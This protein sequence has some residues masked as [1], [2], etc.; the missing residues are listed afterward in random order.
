[1]KILHISCSPRG[2]ASGSYRLSE[3]IVAELLTRHPQAAVIAR[4]LWQ[5]PEVHID[6]AYAVALAAGQAAP[7]GLLSAALATS[8]AWIGELETADCLVI[9]TP[10]HNFT[11]PA[12]LKTWI[13]HVVRIGRTFMPT[14]QGKAGLLADRP[15]YVAVSAG[16]YRTGERARSPDFLEPYLRAILATIGLKNLHFFSLEAQSLGRE[17]ADEYAASAERE[18]AAHFASATP[19]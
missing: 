4:P 12:A 2:H 10:L 18:V 1:M 13:D 9:A 5:A 15:V 3:R 17:R 14:A 11:V 6:A 19:D 8:E 16:G 7:T